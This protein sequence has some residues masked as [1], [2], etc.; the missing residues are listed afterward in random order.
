VFGGVDG[1]D[2][3][4][5]R[6]L[7]LDRLIGRAS[8]PITSTKMGLLPS[9]TGTYSAWAASSWNSGAADARLAGSVAPEADPATRP[10][11]GD[12]SAIRRREGATL[13]RRTSMPRATGLGLVV[14]A[15]PSK[16]VIVHP[17]IWRRKNSLAHDRG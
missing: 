12:Q 11:R 15:L 4:R 16:A 1:H 3:D 8:E 5:V 10:P 17:S 6:P 14:V 13:I 9:R 7:A 2:V